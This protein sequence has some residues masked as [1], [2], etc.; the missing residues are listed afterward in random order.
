MR[1][2]GPLESNSSA[3]K[4]FDRAAQAIEARFG[5]WPVWRKLIVFVPAL[6]LLSALLVVALSAIGAAL[7]VILR[8]HH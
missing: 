5:A 8:L 2:D 6:V 4:R 7:P 3:R 1:K